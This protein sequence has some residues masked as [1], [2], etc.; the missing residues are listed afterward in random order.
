M[1]EIE[2]QLLSAFQNKG[3]ELE[4]VQLLKSNRKE[5]GDFQLNDAM[6]L[7]KIMHKSPLVIANEMKEILEQTNL[8]SNITIAGVGFINLTFKDEILVQFIQE[9][10]Q[11]PEKNIDKLSNDTIIIDYGGANI[12]KTLHVGHLRS[13][14]S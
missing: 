11:N 9:I 2:A 6:K 4:K 5:L 3:Y 1:K 13:A 14:K 7:A 10:K 8:F 12:A